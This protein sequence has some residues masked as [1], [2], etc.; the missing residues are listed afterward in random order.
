MNTTRNEQSKKQRYKIKIVNKNQQI[1]NVN[2]LNWFKESNPRQML[3]NFV[4]RS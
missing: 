3:T 2:N 1:E 4:K